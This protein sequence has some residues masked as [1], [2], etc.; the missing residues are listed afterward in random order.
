MKSLVFQVEFLS[1]IVLPATSNT[2]G[3]IKQLDFIPG[4]N[5]LGMVAS[6]YGDFE[7]SFNVFHSGDVKFGDATILKYDTQ[8]YKMPLS[9]FHEKL[10]DTML[11]NHHLIE[12]F[13]S[14]KQLKQKRNGYITKEKEIIEVEYN[15]SQKSAY[16]KENRKS[17][18]SSM[19]GYS[20]IQSASK[21]QFTLKYTDSLSLKD[22]EL[23]KNNLIGKKRLGKSK[24]A[25][26][27][28]VDIQLK[29]K[30]EELSTQNRSSE[31]V[32][33]L[34]SRLALTDQEG[35]PTYDLTYLF[36]GLDDKNIVYEKTQI[37]RSSF[38]PYN[39]MRQTK[40]YERV[41]INRGSVIVL[42]DIK[43]ET[44]PNYA[45]AYQSEGFG[46][47][48]VNPVFLMEKIFKLITN[49]KDEENTRTK[50]IDITSDLVKFLQR[51]EDSKKEKLDL[52]NE[53]DTFKNKHYKLYVKI[54]KSQ[55]GKIR[56]ICTSAKDD[57]KKEIEDYVSSGK[58][59]WDKKQID[60][61]LHSS[62]DLQFFKLLSMQMPKVRNLK[63][64]SS[65][66]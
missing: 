52:A 63:E 36:D 29:G 7:D 41:C 14:S 12:N 10:D 1:D 34:N 23:I 56:S 47:I 11:Y 58:V 3:N 20:A 65:N 37:K 2:E 51:R 32:L 26:Y 49:S 22:L 42:K 17:L 35:N 44:I 66:D 16:D 50:E 25:Q 21:W 64:E 27:G 43:I 57:F 46:E 39:G 31:L 48:I 8:T 4:S 6:K 45:G 5:F 28:L 59:T 38:T 53:V 33:Y 18:D 55:W 15:Y 60:T 13:S 30:N 62:E 54:N 40:D 19:Y 9:Y 24:S 61:L